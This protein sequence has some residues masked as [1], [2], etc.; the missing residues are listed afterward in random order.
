MWQIR[1]RR[2]QTHFTPEQTEASCSD[3][4]A[5]GTYC[6][7]S[8]HKLWLIT[9]TPGQAWDEPRAKLP[10]LPYATPRL[11]LGTEVEPRWAELLSTHSPLDGQVFK[12]TWSQMLWEL[13]KSQP[14]RLLRG[15][16]LQNGCF[17]FLKVL[18][19]PEGTQQFSQRTYSAANQ[20]QSK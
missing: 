4:Q 14:D 20:I 10:N 1:T 13:L 9:V 17:V 11:V 7:H 16:I 3:S 12:C 18:Y 2:L 19:W 8:E 6:L 5:Q 15:R